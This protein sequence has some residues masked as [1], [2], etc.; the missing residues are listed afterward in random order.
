MSGVPLVEDPW[1][2]DAWVSRI[3][4]HVD[5]IARRLANRPEAVA[6]RAAQAAKVTVDAD[7]GDMPEGLCWV[8]AAGSVIKATRDSPTF[9]ACGW[10]LHY[11]R[12]QAGR[13][14]LVML[15]PLM[16]YPTQ[17]VRRGRSWPTDPE[18]LVALADA[19][20]Q[21]SVLDAW[22]ASVVRA[23][24]ARV[25]IPGSRILYRDWQGLLP[26]SGPRSRLAWWAYVDRH[27]PR[28]ATVLDDLP[29]REGAGRWPGG[30]VGE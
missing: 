2:W 28:L 8:C 9:R 4:E 26:V 10:C 14:G 1:D 7:V 25:P 15:L 24:F 23:V 5:G 11:D 27:Q 3:P 22:R 19:W 12:Q 16:Q 21:Q 6:W 18:V 29:P 20:S 30:C 17:P 13:L